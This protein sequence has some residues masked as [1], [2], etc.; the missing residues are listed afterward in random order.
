MCVA[1]GPRRKP[2]SLPSCSRISKDGIE[3]SGGESHASCR[4]CD[5]SAVFDEGRIVE[6]GTHDELLARGGL[7]RRMWDAQAQWY[8]EK[9]R[10]AVV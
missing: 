6:H 7:Y 9:E 1:T 2:T 8:F 4:F 3:F 5:R 10:E